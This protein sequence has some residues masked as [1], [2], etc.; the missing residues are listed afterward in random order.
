MKRTYRLVWNDAFDVW[1]AIAA[2]RSDLGKRRRQGNS[3]HVLPGMVTARAVTAR[4]AAAGQR[5]HPDAM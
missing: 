3:M 1:V 4:A 2:R 5:M